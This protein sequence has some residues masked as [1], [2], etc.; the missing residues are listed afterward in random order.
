MQRDGVLRTWH[1]TWPPECAA[2][3][4][5]GAGFSERREGLA[6]RCVVEGEK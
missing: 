6:W 2:G 3:A 1:I 4:R 5:D